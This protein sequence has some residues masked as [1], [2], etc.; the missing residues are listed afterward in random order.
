M[1]KIIR[2]PTE[3]DLTIALCFLLSETK[4]FAWAPNLGKYFFPQFLLG[5]TIPFWSQPERNCCRDPRTVKARE[6]MNLC[7]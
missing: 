5:K 3:M 1:A 6:P 4:K 2:R 7:Y